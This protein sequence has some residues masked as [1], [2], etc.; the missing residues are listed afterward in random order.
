MRRLEAGEDPEKV[1][2]EMESLFDSEDPLSP[3]S[4]KKLAPK[5]RPPAKDETLYDL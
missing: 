2:A 3:F 1:E 4:K 5:L